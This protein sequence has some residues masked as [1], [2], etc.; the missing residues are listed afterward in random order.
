V[1][2]AAKCEVWFYHLER[3][4]L[5]QILPELLEKTLK[6][7]WRA[8]VRASGQDRL[9]S[10]DSW[11]WAYRDDSF[12]AHGLETEPQAARQPILLTLGESNP[13]GAK[14][15]FLI[16]DAAPGELSEFER[17]MIVF[18]GRDDAAVG[19]ARVRWSRLK[20]QGHPVAYWK[21]GELRGWER[22]A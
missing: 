20:T 7:G 21:Q 9:E 15:L 22:S 3:S 8:L 13:N 1:S 6:K 14:A 4:S 2:E 10:L 5:D 18:D 19:S 16:D 11:L 17:C 12:L